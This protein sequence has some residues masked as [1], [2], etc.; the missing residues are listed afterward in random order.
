MIPRSQWLH[1]EYGPLAAVWYEPHAEFRTAV[2]VVPSIGHEENLTHDG[3]TALARRLVAAGSAVLALQPLGTDQSSGSFDDEGVV[4]RWHASVRSGLGELARSGAAHLQVVALRLGAL[5]L[6]DELHRLSDLHE[7]RTID[8]LV[9][10]SP[11]TSGKRFTRALRVLNAAAD[12]PAAHDADSINVGGFDYP[13]A[14]LADVARHSVAA[15]QLAAAPRVLVVHHERR[16]CD[17]KL[18]AQLETIT[19]LSTVESHDIAQWADGE[20]EG[21]PLPHES[22]TAIAEW[23]SAQSPAALPV[24]PA[25][26]RVADRLTVA[27][28]DGVHE[29]FVSVSATANGVYHP[30]D[31]SDQAALLLLST[32]GPGRSFLEMAREES[33]G[34]R[35]VLRFDFTG[36]RWSG[37]HADGRPTFAY[38]RRGV[39]DVVAAAQWLRARG[40]QS[41]VAVGFCAGGRVLVGSAPLAALLALVAIN[42]ELFEPLRRHQAATS[43]HESHRLGRALL[44]IRRWWS[45]RHGAVASLDRLQSAGVQSMLVF[46]DVDQGVRFL[47][48]FRRGRAVIAGRRRGV[49]VRSRAG[50]GHNLEGSAGATMADD[51]REMLAAVDRSL[52]APT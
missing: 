31:D 19:T 43:R 7:G 41:I 39:G 14:M 30:G 10:W 24:P 2:L 35:A 47:R 29:T 9:L 6:G 18:L 27:E 49:E 28:P 5:M 17:P 51:V 48:S 34:G 11:T 16:P 50:L 3:V 37:E 52:S 36:S 20:M 26:G 40:H 25:S 21:A 45:G 22:I 13:E 4:S 33:R 23:L 1:S 42:V 12:L 46:D 32:S 38:D 44:S 15:E 8:E